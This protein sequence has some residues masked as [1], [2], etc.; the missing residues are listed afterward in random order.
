MK[1]LPTLLSLALIFI[2]FSSVHSKEDCSPNKPI[3]KHVEDQ[4]TVGTLAQNQK[5]GPMLTDSYEEMTKNRDK[6]MISLG[7]NNSGIVNINDT[8]VISDNPKY[9]YDD[10]VTGRFAPIQKRRPSL[11][12]TYE[13]MLMNRDKRLIS[14]QVN[15]TAF[16]DPDNQVVVAGTGDMPPIDPLDNY[17]AKKLESPTLVKN[18]QD[19]MKFL[20]K[21]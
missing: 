19:K 17:Y 21:K 20:Q 14:L 7:L 5:P 16:Y 11:T 6:K 2:F 13:D 12:D 15:K 1:L 4:W 9:V 8:V 18:P 10:G 3:L